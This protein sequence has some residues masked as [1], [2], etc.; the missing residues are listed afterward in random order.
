M[1]TKLLGS[2]L[3]VAIS[4]VV[5]GG[6]ALAAEP[7]RTGFF[8]AGAYQRTIEGV[9]NVCTDSSQECIS[10]GTVKVKLFKKKDGAWV[11][12]ASKPAD[13]E[14]GSYYVSFADAPRSGR[15]KMTAIYSGTDTYDPSKGSITGGC[16]EE[17]WM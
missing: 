12:I 10:E 16:G 14:G 13:N 9:I 6:T 7:T 15:C 3:S 17:N 4:I 8:G 2:A 1:R 5:L 11:K